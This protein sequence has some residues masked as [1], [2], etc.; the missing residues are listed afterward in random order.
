M[1]SDAHAKLD[2]SITIVKHATSIGN[3]AS[4]DECAQTYKGGFLIEG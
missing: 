2:K 3:S 4:N 1:K